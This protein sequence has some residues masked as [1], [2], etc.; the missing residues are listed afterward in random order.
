M[1]EKYE[2]FWY[3]L[4]GDAMTDYGTMFPW[5]KKNEIIRPVSAGFGYIILTIFVL[6]LL[7]SLIAP[8]QAMTITMANPSGIAERD[9]VVYYPNG[10]MQG[11]YNSTSVID[12]D[13]TTDYIFTM[14]PLSSNL[15]EDPADWLTNSAFPFIQTNVTPL[16]VSLALIGIF[17]ARWKK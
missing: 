13:N 4:F 3:R 16:V 8:A 17:F 11:Y 12:I 15:L 1:T 10:T 2:S 5:W 9:I 14:K 7:I 6:M